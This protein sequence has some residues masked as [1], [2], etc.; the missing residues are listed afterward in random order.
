MNLSVIGAHLICSDTTS[1][2]TTFECLQ[3]IHNYITNKLISRIA[4]IN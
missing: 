3:L 1:I 2:N 4:L